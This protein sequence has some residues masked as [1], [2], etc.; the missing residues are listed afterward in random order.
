M[1]LTIFSRFTKAIV[2]S[3]HPFSPQIVVMPAGNRPRRLG[4]A[5]PG[6]MRRPERVIPVSAGNAS[7]PAS[8][9]A[10]PDR[11]PLGSASLWR[12]GFPADSI[13]RSRCSGSPPFWYLHTSGNSEKLGNMRDTFR[14]PSPTARCNGV[15]SYPAPFRTATALMGDKVLFGGVWFGRADLRFREKR[16][17]TYAGGSE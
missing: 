3:I 17:R 7:R 15:S 4:S 11:R 2:G 8:R 6:A 5:P 9:N 10:T 14:F 1:T 16:C 13:W 12:Q